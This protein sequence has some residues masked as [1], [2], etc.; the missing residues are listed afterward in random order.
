MLRVVQVRPNF[1]KQDFSF[2]PMALNDLME[3][4]LA[5]WRGIGLDTPYF[6]TDVWSAW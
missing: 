4:S 5:M 3:S 2:H 1:R 6:G